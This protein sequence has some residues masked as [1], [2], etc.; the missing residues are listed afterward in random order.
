MAPTSPV[1]ILHVEHVRGI[2]LQFRTRPGVFSAKG[3]D[4]GTR[5]IDYRAFHQTVPVSSASAQPNETLSMASGTCR[6]GPGGGG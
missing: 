2:E 3:L 1:P 4:D 5:L 6:S